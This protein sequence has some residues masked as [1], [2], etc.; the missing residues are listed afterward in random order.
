MSLTQGPGKGSK[1][2]LVSGAR[3]RTDVF[4][5]FVSLEGQVLSDFRLAGEEKAQGGDTIL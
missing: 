5:H 4:M 2:A 1:T 3:H